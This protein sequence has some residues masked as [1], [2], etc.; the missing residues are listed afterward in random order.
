MEMILTV[1]LNA[2]IDK[3][4]V[5]ENFKIGEVM[6][7]KECNCTAGGKGINVSKVAAIAGEKVLATGFVGGHAGAYLEETLE[8]AGIASD[9]VHAEGET[10]S[11]IN[12]FDSVNRTQTEFLEPGIT[13]T[14]KDID[15]FLLKYQ[16]LVRQS[17]VISISGS[18][19][20]GVDET[21]YQKL[22]AIAK[23]AGKKV[24]LDTS[25][26]LLEAGIAAKP[27]FVKPNGD[28]IRALLG[29]EISDEHSAAEAAKALCS[30]GIETVVVSLG[31]KGAVAACAEGVYYAIP[32][33]VEVVNT[34]G[35]GDS[36][37]AAFA[38]GF[39]RGLPVQECLRLA[40]AVSSSNA[41]CVETGHYIPAEAEELLSKVEIRSLG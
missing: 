5:V 41:H 3:R 13:V 25:G 36:M 33:E 31:K 14:Q 7:V 17:D 24:L 39:R 27:S 35:C 29:R 9:F 32:P 38:V 26:K 2:A 11:C 1:T 23:E 40:T 28:E 12:I 8:K 22:I 30:Q 6:R 21:L 19:P 16:E 34:V 4:Y 10:R 37:V 18:V 20:R 15:A